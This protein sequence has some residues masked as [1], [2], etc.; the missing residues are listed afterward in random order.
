MTTDPFAGLGAEFSDHEHAFLRAVLKDQTG[1]THDIVRAAAVEILAH[2]HNGRSVETVRGHVAQIL[3]RAWSRVR[4]QNSPRALDPRR[5]TMTR[6]AVTTVRHVMPYLNYFTLEDS[7][8]THARFDGTQSGE[9]QR[10]VF[11]MADAVTVLPYDPVRDRVLLVEQLRFGPFGR[12]D[13]YPWTYEPVAGRI[14]LGEPPEVTA[15]REAHEEAGV[16][17][18]ALHKAGDYYVSPGAATEFLVSYVGIADLPDD[19]AGVGGLA[20][21]HEDIRAFLVPFDA[22]MAMCDAHQLDTGPLYLTALWL[23]RH[24]DRLRKECGVTA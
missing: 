5:E 15:R 18:A 2:K 14:D 10:A 9:M 12:G 17:L 24:R 7:H 22:L 3:T 6:T 16:T 11:H 4:A 8:F 13:V 23:A 1:L 21:E 19:A 20:E